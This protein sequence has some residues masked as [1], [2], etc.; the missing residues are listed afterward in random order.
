MS[1]SVRDQAQ[2]D[3]RAIAPQ[4]SILSRNARACDAVARKLSKPEGFGDLKALRRDLEK[5]EGVTLEVGDL[6]DR[7]K[8][9]GA[10]ARQW[11]SGEWERRAQEFA[12]ELIAHLV[13]RGL[14]TGDAENG[15]RAHPFSISLDTAEDRAE[16]TFAGEVIGKAV[17][18][19]AERIYRA[20]VDGLAQLE[21]EQTPPDVFADLLMEA[22][23]DALLK[24]TSVREGARIRL[25]EVHFALFVRRQTAAAKSDP[26]RSRLKEYPRCQFAWDLSLLQRHADWLSRDGRRIVLHVAS[27]SAR[28]RADSVLVL[29]PDGTEVALG[30]MQLVPEKE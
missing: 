27:P 19:D 5:L 21:R 25:P 24:R 10:E 17:P 30:D 11:M 4:A 15:V 13:V 9:A 16:L 12:G 28:G 7:A 1:D 6:L 20:Y 2:A 23:G 14:K 22:Y 8:A 3:F 29:A 18:L 26:R